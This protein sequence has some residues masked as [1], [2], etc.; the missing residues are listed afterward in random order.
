VVHWTVL[1]D[2]IDYRMLSLHAV[3]STTYISPDKAS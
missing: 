2:D 1:C 3:Q